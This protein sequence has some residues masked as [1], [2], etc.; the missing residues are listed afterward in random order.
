MS[1]SLLY[2]KKLDARSLG[3]GREILDSNR[4]SQKIGMPISSTSRRNRD[5]VLSNNP[6]KTRNPVPYYCPNTIVNPFFPMSWTN[7]EFRSSFRP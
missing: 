1:S 4:I 7:S 6:E 2:A 3:R 5:F